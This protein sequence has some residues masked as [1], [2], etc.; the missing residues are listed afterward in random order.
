MAAYALEGDAEY[1]QLDVQQR[2][3]LRA[4]AFVRNASPKAWYVREVAKA[5]GDERGP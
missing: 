5:R 1:H 4:K 2:Q 3:S